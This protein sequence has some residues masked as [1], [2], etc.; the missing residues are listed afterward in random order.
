MWIWGGSTQFGDAIIA[1]EELQPGDGS[2][3][4]VSSVQVS[5]IRDFER[6]VWG[7]TGYDY[8]LIW[9]DVA[10]V[11]G[12]E[13]DGAIINQQHRAK[14]DTQL[15]GLVVEASPNAPD[16][17]SERPVWLWNRRDFG[18]SIT[19]IDIG[20]PSNTDFVPIDIVLRAKIDEH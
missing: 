2:D 10:A 19:R 8:P 4:K 11:V 14:I 16:N 18:N 1:R 20:R 15:P 3:D 7:L 6:N 9:Y 17:F 12:T 5:S 13:G